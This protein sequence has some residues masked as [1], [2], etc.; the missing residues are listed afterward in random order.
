MSSS[1][2]LFYLIL[3]SFFLFSVQYF[4]LIWSY[5]SE[6]NWMDSALMPS[7]ITQGSDSVRVSCKLKIGHQTGS[8]LVSWS[9]AVICDHTVTFWRPNDLL[10]FVVFPWAL[11]HLLQLCKCAER[12]ENSLSFLSLFA[13]EGTSDGCWGQK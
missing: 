1:V 10:A 7:D 3:S 9:Q 2:V 4:S 12:L 6:L 8:A 5:V 13:S 11:R